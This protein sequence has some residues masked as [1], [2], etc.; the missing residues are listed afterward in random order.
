MNK[1]LILTIDI[2]LIVLLLIAA[3]LYFTRPVNQLPHWFPGYAAN[4][5]RVHFKHGLAA[6]I[7]AIGGVVYAWFLTGPQPAAGNKTKSTASSVDS[8]NKEQ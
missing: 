1:K 7:L 2:I 3:A 5:S 4:V 8:V 6:L